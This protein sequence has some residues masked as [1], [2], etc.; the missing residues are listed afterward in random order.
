MSIIDGYMSYITTMKEVS[1]MRDNIHPEYNEVK[2]ICA[3]GNE[4]TTGSTSNK[5]IK[6]EVCSECHPFYTGKQRTHCCRP[7]RSIQQ[8]IQKISQKVDPLG[9]DFFCF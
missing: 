6:V 8:K 2:V 9:I 3:C 4:F 5:D 7:C 1:T